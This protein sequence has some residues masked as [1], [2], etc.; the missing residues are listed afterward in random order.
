MPQGPEPTRIE[1]SG[2]TLRV[3]G[4]LGPDEVIAFRTAAQTLVETEHEELVM[5][6]ASVPYIGSVYVRDI[7]LVM[8]EAKKHGR[9]VSVRATQS[10]ARALS[11]VR[12][13]KLGNIE[14]VE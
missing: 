10:V 7:S 2:N 11:M 14:V 12:V 3:C 9:S 5:D 8:L 1:V 6:L 13:D 4:D